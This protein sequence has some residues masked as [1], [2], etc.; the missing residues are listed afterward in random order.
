MTSL[1]MQDL[2]LP[3]ISPDP[4]LFSEKKRRKKTHIQFF[5]D[6]VTIPFQYFRIRTRY[7]CIELFSD[8]KIVLFC[9]DVTLEIRALTYIV[10]RAIRTRC[11]RSFLQEIEA[12]CS[13]LFLLA[14][15]I[16]LFLTAE[17]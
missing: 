5:S 4:H 14:F 17:G 9:S 15:F 7:Y 11:Q 8:C 10:I 3:A 6:P 12:H 1:S 2:P 16:Q 13:T